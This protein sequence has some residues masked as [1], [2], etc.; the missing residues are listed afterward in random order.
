NQLAPGHTYAWSGYLYVP[1]SDT[2]TF[3]IQQSPSL[4][5]T[6]SCPQTGQFGTPSSNPI[7]TLCSAF[8]AGTASQTNTPADAVTF[9]FNGAQRNLNAVTAN[10][11]GAT[12][13]SSP[14]NAGPTHH[15]L[16]RRTCASGTSARASR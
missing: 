2:Y 15:G 7:L 13:P 8:N 11:Y 16:I 3:A 6:L 9:S 4:A 1:T 14:T 10:V 12:T 5:T